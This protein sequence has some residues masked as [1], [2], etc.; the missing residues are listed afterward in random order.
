MNQYCKTK[1]KTIVLQMDISGKTN[2][3]QLYIAGSDNHNDLEN[4]GGD[5]D[6]EFIPVTEKAREALI[7]SDNNIEVL[8]YQYHGRRTETIIGHGKFRS[9]ST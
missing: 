3:D 5:S 6:M 1:R 8:I 2:Q 7:T 4:L 9:S